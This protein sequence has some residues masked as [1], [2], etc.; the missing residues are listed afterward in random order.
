MKTM[1]KR[2]AIRLG[3]AA[4]LAATG[5]VTTATASAATTIAAPAVT[6]GYVW[7][8]KTPYPFTF[9]E[10][11]GATAV[12]FEYSIDGAS[13]Q[14]VPAVNDSAQADL[15]FTGSY[16]TLVVYAVAA[17]G[18]VSAAT[19]VIE[20]PEDDVWAADKDIN[21]DGLPD[22]LT[23][24]GP[25]TGLPSGM[26][27]ALGVGGGRLSVPATNLVD[28]GTNLPTGYLDG[29]QFVMGHYGQDGFEDIVAYEP[30]ANDDSALEFIGSGDGSALSDGASITVEPSGWSADPFTGDSSLQITNGY[31]AA[32]LGNGLDGLFSTEGDSAHGYALDYLE[33]DY[34]GFTPIQ[35]SG[36]MTPDGT[37]DWNKWRI[38]GDSVQSGIAL[39][40]W[41]ESTGALYLWEG[42]TVTDNGNQTGTMAYSQYKVSCAWNKGV[43]LTTLEAANFN[44]S[45]TPGLWAVDTNAVARAYV[46]SGLST[47]HNARIKQVASSKLTATS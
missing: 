26:W 14:S 13:L 22:L 17:D 38:A 24:G 6:S 46:V 23:A 9:T 44:G 30:G 47:T 43:K 31:D 1:S 41:N 8:I 27:Q 2:H 34:V 33:A 4:V 12:K 25:G 20:E 39:Y 11:T 40:L 16:D 36:Q 32:G 28:F 45:V 15:E 35:L 10:G 19:T 3:T 7:Y 29:G 21:G 42:I 18:T 5:G 37:A